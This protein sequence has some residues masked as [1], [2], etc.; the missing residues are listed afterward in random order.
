M[1]QANGPEFTAR[2]TT[3]TG[4]AAGW[5]FRLVQFEKIPNSTQ[6]KALEQTGIQFVEYLPHNAYLMAFPAGYAPANLREAGIRAVVEMTPEMKTHPLL[7]ERP[8][9]AWSQRPDQKAA[10]VITWYPQIDPARVLPLI[11]G[12]AEVVKVN[13]MFHTL[14]LI[15]PESEILTYAANPAVQYIEPCDPDPQPEN[16]TGR[17]LHRSSSIATEAAFSAGRKY[18]G[19]GVNVGMGDDGPIG[20]HLDYH[21]RTDQTNVILNNGN[22][23]DHVAG[24]IMGS[25]NLN[26]L[27]RG[28]AYGAFLY[29][30][31]VWDA[32]NFSPLTHAN[33][34]VMI[35]STS[36]SNGCNAG[37]T[38]F[39]RT[40]D[41]TTRQNPTLFH[42]F[43][44]GNDGTSDCGYGAGAN[45]GNVT[46][47]VKVGKNVIAVANVTSGGVVVNSSSKGPAAD[48]RIKPEVSAKGTDVTSPV[49]EN[50][51]ATFTGT[52]MA[53]PGVSGTSAQ[54]YQAYR[55][56]NSGND[57]DAALIKGLLMNCAT[58]AGN[59]GPDFKYGYGIINALSAVK[60]LEDNRYLKAQVDQGDTNL[61]TITVP[62][63]VAQLKIMV[64]WTD[65]EGSA[66]A[67]VA[68]VN[69]LDMQVIDPSQTVFNPWVLDH[70]P[71]ATAL[72]MPAT[73][74]VDNLN[75]MEQV[76]I[77][78]PAAGT[79]QIQ[80]AGKAVPQGP[81]DYFVLYEML[82]SSITLTYPI[83]GEP[84][85]PGETEII[86]WDAFGTW[87][88][89][90]GEYSLDGGATWNSLFTAG[91][92]NS[93]QY[94]WQVP[95][96]AT[97]DARI[98]LTRGSYSDM[99]EGPFSVI[100]V[101]S[102]LQVYRSCPNYAVL[103]YNPVSGATGYEASML[104]AKYMD[105]TAVSGADTVVI[106]G[107]SANQSYWFSVKATGPNNA[108]GRR[109]I[110]IQKTPGIF[111]CLEPN[112]LEVTQLI[113]PV[114]GSIQSCTNPTNMPVRMEI[115]SQSPN[116]MTNFQVSYKFDNGSVVTETYTDT[117]HGYDTDIYTFTTA[118]ISPSTGS[119]N[120]VAWCN[121][122]TDLYR[123]NDTVTT[124]FQVINTSQV[125]TLPYA[126]NFEAFPN[127]SVQTNCEGTTCN[128]ID[129]W[130]NESNGTGDDIDWR[131]N[132]GN[133][134]STGTGPSM[135]HNPGTAF[136]RYLYLEASNCFEKEGYVISPCIDL[137]TA[138]EP[139]L[140]FWFHLYGA[141][142]GDLHVD[143]YADGAWTIDATTMMGSNWFDIWWERKIDLQPWAGKIINVR[144]R[145]ITGTDY[146][147]D[148]AID[149]I[150]FTETFVGTNPNQLASPVK[151]YPNPS[152]GIF[153][154]EMEGI[155]G[156]SLELSVMDMQG[157]I[158]M[159]KNPSFQGDKYYGRIDLSAY[160][161]GIY[162]LSVMVDGKRFT[163][164]LSRL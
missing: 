81:Q 6:R 44:A 116:D 17:T 115:K 72:D 5:D 163:K 94:A 39:A 53:C 127:C 34:Q 33:D 64:N 35:T 121:V 23:G 146:T 51:Y 41:Q 50:Q 143:I 45:W 149:D 32:V 85:R 73:R 96:G 7:I 30:Y 105:S 93:R 156:N 101:P 133:T 83:G 13:E 151:V 150:N 26:P 63:G 80:I 37:Y 107:L 67:S 120:L 152:A 71:S 148:M 124:N 74:S 66:G 18:N 25:G 90:D 162:S 28:M 147:S 138:I 155:Q 14:E 84:F 102:S 19:N 75:N 11:A 126:Q 129:G 113:A 97:G 16:Y 87:G 157:R 4:Q 128:L 161:A 123:A 135:D 118:T 108:V 38:S 65:F 95:Q 55:D 21:G 29:V 61:H 15:I 100:G 164:K 8:L 20:P 88:T 10:V 119:H 22:H 56:L 130:S 125:K 132:S 98:R 91:P 86:R 54:L 153:S 43:S 92:A 40:A 158:L 144:W 117:L 111:N 36:Y 131:V 12:N 106:N 3:F 145:G 9:P 140:S 69:N 79:Y 1:P 24:T 70:S 46:G 141:A 47:G 122:S 154:L 42:V 103:K 104:G 110:A 48:G 136:G 31:S 114:N 142:M 59:P 159:Q 89:F 134:A 160:P 139:E 57:P 2:S 78:A 137:T 99:G 77:D 60:T 58:D 82:D 49:D 62:A 109:A 68:L 27:H 52:S 76:T 112:D